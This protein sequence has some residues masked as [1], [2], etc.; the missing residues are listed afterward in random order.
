MNKKQY[1]IMINSRKVELEKFLSQDDSIHRRY[2]AKA[3]NYRRMFFQLVSEYF[4]ILDIL[5]SPKFN[6]G[7]I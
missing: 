5:S 2:A 7:L 3:R 6:R 1:L 4:E